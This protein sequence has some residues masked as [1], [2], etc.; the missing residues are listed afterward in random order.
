[1]EKSSQKKARVPYVL[2]EFHVTDIEDQLFIS[3]DD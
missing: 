3:F 2:V 1:M